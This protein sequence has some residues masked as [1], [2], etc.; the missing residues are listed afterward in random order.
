MPNSTVAVNQHGKTLNDKHELKADSRA[1]KLAGIPARL[2]GFTLAALFLVLLASPCQAGTWVSFGPQTYARYSGTPTVFT[3][4]FSVLNPNTVYVLKINNGGLNG[5]FPRSTGV[6]TLN[7]VRILGPRELNPR[8]PVLI[9]P[10]LLRSN[11]QLA[12][13]LQGTTGS[14]ILL[15]IIGL[16]LG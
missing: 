15:Q 16:D 2:L 12:V 5:Q 3:S 4:S 11:N 10:V 8:I 9:W 1:D 7:G 6:I 13:E 14:G